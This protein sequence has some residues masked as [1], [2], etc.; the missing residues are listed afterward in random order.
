MVKLLNS[1]KGHISISNVTVEILLF[2]P[3][4]R[5]ISGEIP[6]IHIQ[7]GVVMK[8]HLP[9]SFIALGNIPNATTGYHEEPL[10]SLFGI[11]DGAMK[12]NDRVFLYGDRLIRVNLNWI[13]DYVLTLKGF[14]YT[15]KDIT[16][17]PDLLL[18]KQS[19][20]G[21]FYEIIAPV[22]DMHSGRPWVHEGKT[23]QVSSPECCYY[24]EGLDFGL[25]RLELEADIEYLMVEG[26]YLIWQAVGDDGYLVRNLPRLGKGLRYIMTDPLRWDKAHQLA[27][28][29]RTLD[30]WDFLDSARS[31]LDRSIHSDDPM[32]I[33]HGDNT[34]LYHSKLLMA[35]M[36]RVLG[37]E[38]A[39]VRH[40]EEAAAL[41]E[42]IMKHLW[43]GR[44]FRHFLAL[45]PVDYGVDET[46]QM[47]LSNSYA[48][49]RGILN[50]D[51]RLAVID[52]Y[53]GMRKKYGGE[54][55]DFRNLEPAYPNFHEM[56]PGAYVNG[57]VAPFVAGEL[58]LG[59][60]ET[61]E[62]VYGVDILKRMGR[63]ISREGK[64]AFL[65]DWN[66]NDIGGGPRCWCGAEL[67]NAECAGLAG[68]R[69]NG[70]S[71][72]DVT[73]SPRFAAAGEKRAY[74]RLE[75]A[76]SGNFVEYEFGADPEKKTLRFT[77]VSQ[78]DRVK[79][80]MF[81]PD[82]KTP[83]EARIGG[84]PVEFQDETVGNSH[85]AVIPDFPADGTAEIRYR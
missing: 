73:L 45:D 56:K 16:S 76:A 79:L 77:L 69:D 35:K 13:R 23:I 60:F 24:E 67:M 32:G 70:K 43:N 33:F 39:A 31:G 81:V 37:N 1:G 84:N 63:K 36:Y 75:Y 55:D 58:A 65:Y 82:G 41:R 71:F 27:K 2:K 28:R 52:S 53:R 44:F 72:R 49:N 54:Y 5:I 8:N 51:E 59:A 50:F 78:H 64:I 38:S 80:R 7:F 12:F 68:V 3:D 17:F 15:E 42:R 66:G 62:E 74:V 18:E 10:S 20:K 6:G 34:G 30:T 9:G 48:L 26:V 83:Y 61:G 22:T 11:C 25:C 19:E 57:A 4:S 29:P 85:Y 21:F 14:R 46:Y 47:S 40:E